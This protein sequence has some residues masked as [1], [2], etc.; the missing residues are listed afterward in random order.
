MKKREAAPVLVLLSTLA[1][2]Y[3]AV[4]VDISAT[5]ARISAL[6]L[7]KPEEDLYF[8]VAKLK[9]VASVRWRRGGQCGIQFQEPL[10]QEEVI[11]VRREAAN[12]AGLPPA[13]RAAMDD[14]VLGLAR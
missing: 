3:E 13:L 9:T 11:N 14:W 2:T 8:S 4:L 6:E 12:Y 10:R 7:P 1:R 5:G